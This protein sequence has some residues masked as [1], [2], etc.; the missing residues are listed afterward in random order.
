MD[1]NALWPWGCSPTSAHGVLCQP[2]HY[3]LYLFVV[4]LSNVDL[5]LGLNWLRA[6]GVHLNF[7]SGSTMAQSQYS[8]CDFR[9]AVSVKAANHPWELF[10]LSAMLELSALFNSSR[11]EEEVDIVAFVHP[12]WEQ[13][14]EQEVHQWCQQLFDEADWLFDSESP[15]KH[16][17][18]QHG[19]SLHL[20]LLPGISP[21]RQKVRRLSQEELN[22]FH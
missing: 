12:K 11:A 14:E 13:Q 4:D 1:H 15:H 5:I 6:V 7:V 17:L 19:T 8:Q 9:L 18:P 21:K 22:E 20:E 16:L 3:S 2:E 10:C